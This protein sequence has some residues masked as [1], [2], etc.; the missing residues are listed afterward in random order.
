MKKLLIALLLVTGFA[1]F[2][3]DAQ[4]ARRYRSA[5]MYRG[6]SSSYRPMSGGGGG[7]FQGLMEFERR[8]NAAIF[9]W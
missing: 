2:A 6:Q 8:K 1:L 5:P 7:F 3:S 4:A 9:G